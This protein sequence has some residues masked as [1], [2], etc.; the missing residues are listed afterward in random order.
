MKNSRKCYSVPG[1]AAI[2]K[3][4]LVEK[5]PISGLC[6]EYHIQPSQIYR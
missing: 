6:D 1:K 4:H 2:L 5:V 3:R